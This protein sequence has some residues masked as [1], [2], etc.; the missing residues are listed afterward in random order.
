VRGFGE[1]CRQVRLARG[2]TQTQVAED[3]GLFQSRVSE[4]ERDAYSPG[5]ELAEALA[6]GLDAHLSDLLAVCEGRLA[7]EKVARVG[8]GMAPRAERGERTKSIELGTVARRLA[9]EVVKATEELL[10]SSTSGTTKKSQTPAAAPVPPAGSK[11]GSK[12]KR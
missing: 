10:A 11:R 7:V 3:A 6:R 12:T 8:E 2:K 1:V 9:F 4:I 5:L